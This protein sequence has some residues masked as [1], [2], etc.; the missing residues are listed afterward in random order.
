MGG[1]GASSLTFDITAGA[2]ANRLSLAVMLICTNDGFTGLE[3]IKLPGGFS[4]VTY[5]PAG[6]DA[7][8][9]ANNEQ[10]TQIVDPC[11]AIGPLPGSPSIPNGNG[12]VATSDVIRH[13]PGIQG[14]GDL[15]IAAH[16]WRDPVARITVQRMK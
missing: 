8:T 9:E 13:H 5:T 6:Y 7:G 3:G 15:L 4:A 1:P 16:G 12:R 2:D 10:F 14:G 11:Q